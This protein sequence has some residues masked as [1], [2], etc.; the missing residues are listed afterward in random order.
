[1]G[2]LEERVCLAFDSKLKIWVWWIRVGIWGQIYNRRNSQLCHG[3]RRPVTITSNRIV[4]RVRMRCH[5]AEI[6]RQGFFLFWGLNNCTASLVS[7]FY[8]LFFEIKFGITLMSELSKKF[9]SWVVFIYFILDCR[10]V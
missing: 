4:T 6:T 5:T 8:F 2:Y 10:I 3:N 7:H 9:G 1:M